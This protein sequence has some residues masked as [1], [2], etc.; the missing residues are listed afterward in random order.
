MDTK[1]HGSRVQRR[2]LP[3][4][5]AWCRQDFGTIV[6]LLDHVDH[7]HLDEYPAAA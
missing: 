3:T 2:Q 6:E 7:R 4:T 5:C 1:H